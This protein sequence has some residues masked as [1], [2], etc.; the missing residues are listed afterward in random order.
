LTAYRSRWRV[1]AGVGF[2]LALWTF[3]FLSDALGVFWYRVTLSA[4]VL[5]V[6]ATLVD[7]GVMREQMDEPQ[8]FTVV[9]G[10]GAGVFL[11]ALFFLG[12]S[13][14]EPLLEGG[15]SEV[16]LFRLE[17]PLTVVASTLVV[18]SFCEEYF[19]RAFIQRR[20]SEGYGDSWG[21]IAST[22]SYALIHTPTMNAPLVLAAL[23]AG[24]FWGLLYKWYGSLWMVYASHLV[25]TELVFVLLPLG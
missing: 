12:Y 14:L 7:G 9:A 1:I 23:I 18:T 17:T 20:L 22:L 6:Y 3:T 11:Y 15:A 5:A 8:L 2:A 19:W 16:Y 10:V 24:L 13:S 25:W 21:I 4:T